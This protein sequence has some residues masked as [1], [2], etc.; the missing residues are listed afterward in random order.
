MASNVI[1]N[2]ASIRD[3]LEQDGY[4]IL[5]DVVSMEGIESLRESLRRIFS[6]YG[7]DGED[8]FDTIIRLNKEDKPTLFRIYQFV[9]QTFTSLD[10]IRQDILPIAKLVLP[11][12]IVIDLGSAIIFG[13]PN[14][15]RLTWQWHQECTYD[16]KIDHILSINMPVFERADLANGTVSLLKGSHKLGPLPFDKVQDA[17]DAATSLVPQGVEEFEQQYEI[18]HFVADPGDIILFYENLIHRSNQ[19]TT[20]R[21]RVTFVGRLT[22]INTLPE[23]ATI[24]DGKPY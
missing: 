20:E 1:E 13:I 18:D 8:I 16:P 4:V 11:G 19:N 17:P 7:K 5:K 6:A 23:H 3:Q 24:I 14:D 2:A 12:G 15:D 10:A 9:S 22:S 21:P